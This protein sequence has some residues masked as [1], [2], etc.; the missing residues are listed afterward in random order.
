MAWGSAPP[1]VAILRKE[2]IMFQN[3]VIG[4][5]LVEPWTLISNSPEEFEKDDKKDTLFT[6]ERFLP[7]LLVDAGVVKS[8]SEVRRNKPQFCVDLNE[9]TCHWVNWGKKKIF[10]I[11]GE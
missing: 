10:I 1:S 4:K 8:K 2:N 6:D 9:V 7:A 3:I 11:V 5:P